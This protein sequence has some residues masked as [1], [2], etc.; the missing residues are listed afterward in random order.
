MSLTIQINFTKKLVISILFLFLVFFRCTD[1]K[2]LLPEDISSKQ[3][4]LWESQEIKDYGFTLE[5][6][7]YCID[8]YT[9]PKRVEVRNNQIQSLNG[10]PYGDLEYESYYTFN[11]FFD[12]IKERQKENPVVEN[13][14]YDSIYGFP[15]Y[16]YF[17][18]SEMIADEEIGY[19]ITEFV[20]N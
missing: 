6:S 9:L 12:Y 17:D 3:E 10:I 1:T 19:T 14:S 7:C 8:E 20:I 4:K 2:E 11:E 5:I 15:T 16:I 13:L 18:I